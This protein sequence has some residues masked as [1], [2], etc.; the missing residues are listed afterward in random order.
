M[1]AICECRVI[2]KSTRHNYPTRPSDLQRLLILSDPEA[3]DRHHH[4]V[5][6][7]EALLLGGE[8]TVAVDGC[9]RALCVRVSAFIESASISKSGLT[10][11]ES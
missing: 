4:T 1:I 9:G 6:E 3:N 7:C 8:C 2:N 11:V 10:G 5:V